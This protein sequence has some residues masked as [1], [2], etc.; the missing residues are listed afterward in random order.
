M[1]GAGRVCKGSVDVYPD[2]VSARTMNVRV[3]RI[4]Y[5]LGIDLPREEM[6]KML[7]SLE[8]K[9]EGSG[10]IMTVTPP[11]VRQDLLEEELVRHPRIT[12]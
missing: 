1:I 7:Q 3:S 8:I 10:D 12:L 5:V 4:N 11:T 6:V 9:V 2:P